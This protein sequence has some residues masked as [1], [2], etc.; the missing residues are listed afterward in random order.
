MPRSF[1]FSGKIC[2][3]FTTGNIQKVRYFVNGKKGT[4]ICIKSSHAERIDTKSME[5]GEWQQ[6]LRTVRQKI[7]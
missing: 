3:V 5:V 6:I 1:P 2:G 4:H 7:T